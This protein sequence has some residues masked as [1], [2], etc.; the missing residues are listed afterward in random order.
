MYSEIVGK[1][2]RKRLMDADRVK[3]NNQISIH[4]D[5]LIKQRA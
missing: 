1:Q 4:Y 3:S 2:G 5:W